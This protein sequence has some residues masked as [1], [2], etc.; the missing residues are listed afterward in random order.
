MLW[1]TGFCGCGDCTVFSSTFAK[2][3]HFFC[4]KIDECLSTFKACNAFPELLLSCI[5][6]ADSCSLLLGMWKCLFCSRCL[7]GMLCCLRSSSPG[8]GGALPYQRIFGARDVFIQVMHACKSARVYDFFIPGCGCSRLALSVLGVRKTS[9]NN[10]RGAA[11][12]GL[13][14]ASAG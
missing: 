14:S 8:R 3:Q 7:A 4:I 6:G 1:T 9:S 13:S 10:R 5:H 11:E 2:H 12:E